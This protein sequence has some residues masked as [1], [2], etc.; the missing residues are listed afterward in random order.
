MDKWAETDDNFQ[1]WID[2]LFFN[3]VYTLRQWDMQ[4]NYWHNLY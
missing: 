2:E 4:N 3:L 1:L